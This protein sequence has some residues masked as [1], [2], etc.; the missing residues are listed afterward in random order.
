MDL[1]NYTLLEGAVL[2]D[3]VGHIQTISDCMEVSRM[4]PNES[5]TMEIQSIPDW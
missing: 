3:S 5:V 1:A 4:A 2:A